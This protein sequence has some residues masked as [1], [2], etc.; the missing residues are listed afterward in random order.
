MSA[1][2]VIVWAERCIQAQED[3]YMKRVFM[4]M[5]VL[6]LSWC[7]ILSPG[8][9]GEVTF[10]T[11]SYEG[12]ELAK[13]REWEKAWAGKKVATEN[14]DQVKDF[15]HE[16]VYNAL[17]NPGIFGAESLW[18]SVVPYRPYTISSG[19]IAATNKHAPASKLDNDGMLVGYS[20]VAGI[21]FPQPKTALEMAWNFDGNSHG[22]S[23]QEENIGDVVNCQQKT[24]RHAGMLRWE[25]YWIGRVD[26]APLPRIPEKEN[27]RGIARSW[28]QRHTAPIDFMDSTML[29][30]KYIDHT[31]QE[32][33]WVYTVM[34][35]RIRRYTASQRTDSI[36]GTDMVFDDQDGW[37]THLTHNTYTSKGRADL[38]V[39]R[40]QDAKQLQRIKGQA[41]W[42]GVQRERV[43]HWVVE[44]QSKTP[45]YL[46]SRQIWYLD[47]ETWQMN[48]KV[49]Y[50]R[51]GEL[52]KMYELFYD[53]YPN[54][55]G[56]KT[57]L[58][59]AEHSVDLIRHHGSP[60][61]REGKN[62]GAYIRP[63]YFQTKSLKDKSY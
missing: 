32:D 24:E 3:N 13:V 8:A 53:E 17:K 37:Y 48:F 34:F 39:A 56:G 44:V 35:R 60:N 29:E 52:W 58:F 12:E 40:H 10:P 27:Q 59:S 51:K 46:Y 55:S 6:L 2:S 22:D 25:L 20:D 45:G 41:F 26:S 19:M 15:L 4:S 33:L 7:V 5:A 30:L 50:N 63:D 36:D 1:S 49:M 42:N 18:F 57:S 23:H 16:A 38:L 62:V 47:P 11:L 9:A 28:F 54:A 43:N 61:I 14:A 21:P 31:K